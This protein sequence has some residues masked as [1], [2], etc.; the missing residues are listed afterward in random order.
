MT[1]GTGRLRRP[2]PLLLLAVVL[3]GCTG[4]GLGGP[5]LPDIRGT[6]TGPWELDR[7]T[8]VRIGPCTDPGTLVIDEQS[9]DR[10]RGRFEIR[11]TASCFGDQTV[12]GQVTEGTLVV[13]ESNTAVDFKLEPPGA[14]NIYEAVTS[15][16]TVFADESLFGFVF[17]GN[18]EASSG[19]STLQCADGKI[20]VSI[21]VDLS[22]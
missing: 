20:S 21:A 5:E 1:A 12:S 6:Y 13:Q 14:S 8:N 11:G 18:L 15:C 9:G 3:L 17:D 10:F 4:D 19:G 2:V 16:T 22:K 7:P